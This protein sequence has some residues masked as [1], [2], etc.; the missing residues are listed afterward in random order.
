MKNLAT[1]PLETKNN[2]KDIYL[3]TWNM[4]NT[5]VSIMYESYIVDVDLLKYWQHYFISQKF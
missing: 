4:D 3:H 5:W 1:D 2:K